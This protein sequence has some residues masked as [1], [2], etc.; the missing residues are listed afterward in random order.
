MV[1][2][3]LYSTVL[4]EE[5]KMKNFV[6]LLSDKN[7]ELMN[8]TLI[9][10]HVDYLRLK[11]DEGCLKY[12]G[13]CTDGSALMILECKTREQAEDIVSNDPFSKVSYYQNV[14]IR[15]IQPA[16]PENNFLLEQV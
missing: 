15:E 6:V 4:S 14:E 16:N 9:N 11:W 13:P 10:G 8:E 1:A 2:V 12:C 7:R 3:Y 5:G